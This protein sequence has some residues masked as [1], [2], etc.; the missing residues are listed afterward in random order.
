MLKLFE[1]LRIYTEYTYKNIIA[2]EP[3]I[4]TFLTGFHT[5]DNGL[6]IGKYGINVLQKKLLKA[7]NI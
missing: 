4:R 7:D 3:E 6:N 5:E 2:I 1:T